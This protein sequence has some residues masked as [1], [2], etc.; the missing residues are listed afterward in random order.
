MVINFD[1]PFY[2]DRL[3]D[4]HSLERFDSLLE[5]VEQWQVGVAVLQTKP[6]VGQWT[7][8]KITHTHTHTHTN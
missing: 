5:L 8:D 6:E 7:V 2:F 4:T 3:H 1:S